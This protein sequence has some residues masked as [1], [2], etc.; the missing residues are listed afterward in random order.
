[1]AGQSFLHAKEDPR[2]GETQ[3]RTSVVDSFLALVMVLLVVGLVMLYSASY[4]QSQ[5]D[6]GYESSTKY[7]QKQGVCALLGLGCM[8]FFSR[9]RSEVWY[10]CAWPVYGLS[11]GL[12]LLVL[13]AALY[14]GQ[15]ISSILFVRDNVANFMHIVGGLCGTG[16]GYAMHRK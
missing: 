12:L 16:F 1:M 8:W 2:R 4:A 3:P 13:V 6:T 11:I 10:R 14:A 7:L 5:Y 9:I 15:E